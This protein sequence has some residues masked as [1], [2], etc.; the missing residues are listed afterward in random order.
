MV[1]LS[2]LSCS[3]LPVQLPAHFGANCEDGLRVS[4]GQAT[5]D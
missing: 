4:D 1:H 3:T 5:P 2:A